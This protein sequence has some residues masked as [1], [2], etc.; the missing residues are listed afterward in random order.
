MEDKNKKKI[1]VWS[2]RMDLLLVRSVLLHEPYQFKA[3]TQKSGAS[4]NLI[5]ESLNTNDI[6]IMNV[7]NRAC[8]ERTANLRAKRAEVV[9]YEENASGITPEITE[10]DC[11]IDEII[12]RISEFEVIF[13]LENDKNEAKEASDK[14]AAEDVRLQALESYGSTKKRKAGEDLDTSNDSTGSA[15]GKKKQRTS[16]NDAIACLQDAALK[17]DEMQKEELSL[18]GEMFRYEKDKFKEEL[19]LRREQFD[20]ARE[21]EKNQNNYNM[22]LL[23]NMQE[24]RRQQQQQNQQMMA[25]ML[26]LVK[27]MSRQAQN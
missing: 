9:K 18:K 3:R 12:E 1:N 27:N 17:K 16:G 19:K 8:R 24:D 25:M 7:D 11:I 13:S 15:S 22:S 26:S 14:K 2:P 5:A 20:I 21:R 6:F 10:T 4:W 23:N